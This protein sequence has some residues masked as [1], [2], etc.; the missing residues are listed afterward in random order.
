MEWGENCESGNISGMR[1][2]GYML[3]AMLFHH[4]RGCWL[5]NERRETPL[6]KLRSLRGAGGEK[7]ISTGKHPS[8]HVTR[9]GKRRVHVFLCLYVPVKNTEQ[10]FGFLLREQPQLS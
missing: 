2:G 10:G 8:K 5:D 7:G 4:A 3:V 6:R 1:A 9:S